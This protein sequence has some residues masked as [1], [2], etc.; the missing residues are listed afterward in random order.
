MGNEFGENEHILTLA[1]T[2]KHKHA[3]SVMHEQSSSAGLD[4]NGWFALNGV[5]GTVVK[6]EGT[7]PD[8]TI[9]NVNGN[10]NSMHDAGGGEPHNN[11]QPSIVV[12]YWLRVG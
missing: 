2:A 1:E 5:G 12:A 4:N 3:V 8:G 6:H 7:Q 9:M 10:G 11:I